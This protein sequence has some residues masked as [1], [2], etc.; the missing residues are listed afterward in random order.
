MERYNMIRSHIKTQVKELLD[1]F[2]VLILK[3][4]VMYNALL[5]TALI[6]EVFWERTMRVLSASLSQ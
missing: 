3:A 6:F 5:Y 2:L 4:E 1:H